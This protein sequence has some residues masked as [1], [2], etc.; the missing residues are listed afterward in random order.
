MLSVL[1]ISYLDSADYVKCYLQYVVISNISES[2]PHRDHQQQ[3]NRDDPGIERPMIARRA[4]KRA[5]ISIFNRLAH[6]FA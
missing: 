4:E 2:Q 3:N 6:A 5:V 1:N